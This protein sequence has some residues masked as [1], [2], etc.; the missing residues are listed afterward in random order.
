MSDDSEV[1]QKI[2]HDIADQNNNN[3]VRNI[4]KRK[5]PSSNIHGVNARKSLGSRRTSGYIKG[6]EHD[7]RYP[8]QHSNTIE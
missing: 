7:V 8:E 6:L 2:F 4:S 5:W 3:D 1:F